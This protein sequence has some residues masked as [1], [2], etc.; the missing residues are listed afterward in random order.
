M[1]VIVELWT[2]HNWLQIDSFLQP[3]IY[4]LLFEY[5]FSC[6]F[7]KVAALHTYIPLKHFKV[8]ISPRLPQ[9][10]SYPGSEPV[11]PKPYLHSIT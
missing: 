3:S 8:F 4:R 5:E 10:M 9:L 6:L 7:F 2:G 1:G 11:A